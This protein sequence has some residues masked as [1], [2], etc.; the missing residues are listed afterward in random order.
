M[1]SD[2]FGL[3]IFLIFVTILVAVGIIFRKAKLPGLRQQ[4]RD[5]FIRDKLKLLATG[6][7]FAVLGIILFILWILLMGKL[8]EV[9]N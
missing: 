6:V 9:L 8:F 5:S 4:P 3:Q 1:D 2:A 7:L